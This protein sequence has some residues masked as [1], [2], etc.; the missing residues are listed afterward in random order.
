MEQELPALPGQRSLDHFGAFVW[1]V[2]WLSVLCFI[3]NCLSVLIFSFDHS[4]IYRLWI[5]GLLLC[6]LY[7][8]AFQCGVICLLDK[9]QLTLL[10]IDHVIMYIDQR[11]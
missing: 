10:S 11:Q 5:Y 4:I 1:Q 2:R 8:Q 6:I 3:N 9:V 7:L